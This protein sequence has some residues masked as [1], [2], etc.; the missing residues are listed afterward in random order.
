MVKDNKINDFCVNLASKNSTPGGGSV[1]AIQG[2]LG[3]G[4]IAMVA[5]ITLNSLK[6]KNFWEINK[7]K[8]RIYNYYSIKLNILNSNIIYYF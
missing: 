3:A 7:N 5:D 8:E 4:L 2:A 1:A 6:Y